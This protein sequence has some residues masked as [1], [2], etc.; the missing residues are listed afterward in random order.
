[1]TQ[2]KNEPAMKQDGG[3]PR[4]DLLPP[5]LLFAVADILTYGAKKYSSNLTLTTSELLS[6]LE[7]SCTCGNTTS[8]PPATPSADTQQKGCA[9]FATP[10]NTQRPN[11]RPATQTELRTSLAGADPAMTRNSNSATPVTQNGNGPTRSGGQNSTATENRP[12]TSST[13]AKAGSN[14]EAS[15][16]PENSP[17]PPM[18]SPSRT[19][20]EYL[21]SKETSA[22]CA[23]HTRTGSSTSTTTTEQE[24]SVGSFVTGATKGW[25]CSAILLTL[26]N[27]HSPTCAVQRLDI[28]PCPSGFSLSITGERNW[29][30]GMSWGR[31]YGALM[32]HMWAW[33]AGE[34]TDQ[35]TGRSHLWHAGACLAFLIAYEERKIGT[36]D[37]KIPVDNQ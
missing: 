11:E 25:D 27:A 15:C 24:S 28:K 37:R 4:M 16:A 23:G 9:S 1:M 21:S 33:W 3:K 26:L 6:K 34:S 8:K 18:A 14:A 12:A 20:S 30:K 29:E 17:S 36:D 2:Q 22:L 31:V 35:E 7:E 13:E 32:R 10:R 5:E 19:R